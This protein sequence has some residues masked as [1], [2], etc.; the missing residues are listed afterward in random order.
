[1]K[2]ITKNPDFEYEISCDQMCGNGHYSM[3][4]VIRVVT[5]PEFILW[6]AQQK[7]AYAQLYGEATPAP[8]MDT[9]ATTSTK[10][11]LKNLVSK[12]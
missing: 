2:Q 1:M 6:R 12:N 11:N 7:A 3:K 4:G 5:K 9:A 8:A 10:I